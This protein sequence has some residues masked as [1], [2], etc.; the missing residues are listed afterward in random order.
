MDF[1]TRETLRLAGKKFE[2][3]YHGEL[4]VIDRVVEKIGVSPFFEATLQEDGFDKLQLVFEENYGRLARYREIERLHRQRLFGWNVANFRRIEKDPSQLAYVCRNPLVDRAVRIYPDDALN[5]VA[6]LMDEDYGVR[7]I[8]GWLG[9]ELPPYEQALEF[10]N[11]A[12]EV[13]VDR[14]SL[15]R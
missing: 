11:P 7:I 12:P 1:L 6:E 14:N 4:E 13:L 10:L 8:S 5:V 15:R 9:D 3:G 2:G